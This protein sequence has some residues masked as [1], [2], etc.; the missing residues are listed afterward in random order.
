MILRTLMKAVNHSLFTPMPKDLMVAVFR[1]EDRENM[2]TL[3]ALATTSVLE[4]L[5]ITTITV[6][7]L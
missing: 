7:I 5:A 4:N 1:V 2:I 3:V 6:T